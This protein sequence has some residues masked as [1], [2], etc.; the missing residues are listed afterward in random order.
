MR[1]NITKQ[2]IAVMVVALV[3]ANK[4]IAGNVYN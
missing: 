3:F 2:F 4:A 1:K